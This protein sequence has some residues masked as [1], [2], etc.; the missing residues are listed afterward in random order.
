LD[1]VAASY[2]HSNEP[3]VSIEGEE[4]LCQ[5]NNHQL[6]DKDFAPWNLLVDWLFFS[7]ID[8]L[9]HKSACHVSHYFSTAIVFPKVYE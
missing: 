2:R 6:L 9:H 3:S 1:A 7:Q 4:F 5:M 8:E